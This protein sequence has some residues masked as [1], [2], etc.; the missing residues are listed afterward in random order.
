MWELVR[1]P[2]RLRFA[3]EA[4]SASHPDDTS[5]INWVQVRTS[6]E[7]RLVAF[8]GATKTFYTPRAGTSGYVGTGHYQGTS[9]VGIT[10]P[11]G[12]KVGTSTRLVRWLSP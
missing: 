3:S 10:S 6:D 12:F 1:T 11:L 8:N 5:N 2:Q 9:T 4:V 7:T